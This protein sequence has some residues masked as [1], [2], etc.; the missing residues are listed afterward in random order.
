MKYLFVIR[1]I[2][3]V[4]GQYQKESSIFVIHFLPILQCKNQKILLL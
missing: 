3:T 4:L 2:S 1:G